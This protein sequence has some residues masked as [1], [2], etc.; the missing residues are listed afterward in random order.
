MRFFS[1]FFGGFGDPT[2]QNPFVKC[3][4]ASYLFFESLTW[5]WKTA[6]NFRE[7]FV[8]SEC[9]WRTYFLY[10]LVKT[11]DFKPTNSL[12][13]SLQQQSVCQRLPALTKCVCVCVW[14]AAWITAFVKRC[15]NRIVSLQSVFPP[16]PLLPPLSL[17]RG[18]CQGFD[19]RKWTLSVMC[20]FVCVCG[21]LQYW[22]IKGGFVSESG[23]EL[24][25]DSS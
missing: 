22:R 9:L 12:S 5:C 23:G 16:S 1:I 15:H 4:P 2:I 13:A 20:V 6:M 14:T 17:L 8:L 11:C 10:S 7:A 25:G 19:T 18:L 21:G 3:F 24:K